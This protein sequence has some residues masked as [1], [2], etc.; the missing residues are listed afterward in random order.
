MYILYAKKIVDY[1]YS[2]FITYAKLVRNEMTNRGYQTRNSVWDK[3]IS[4]KP[5]WKEIDCNDLYC[6]WMDKQ[7]L[8]ICYY[9]LLE[10]YLCGDIEEQDW[11]KIIKK[12]SYY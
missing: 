2:H 8:D 6:G 5:T 9:N 12:Y 3:I 1:P 4:L 10:K 7:Y 11:K